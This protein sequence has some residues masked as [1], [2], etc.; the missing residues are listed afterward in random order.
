MFT[1]T[2]AKTLQTMLAALIV[3]STLGSAN[4]YTPTEK[5]E[6]TDLTITLRLER[7][8]LHN[9]FTR[10]LVF[11]NLAAPTQNQWMSHLVSRPISSTVEPSQPMVSIL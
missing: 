6:P 3:L 9:N 8:P 1:R 4:A 11:E 7:V 10:Q 5:M 2:L